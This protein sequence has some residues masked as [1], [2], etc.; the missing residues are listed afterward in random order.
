MKR[1]TLIFTGLISAI[2]FTSALISCGD[3]DDD[4][5]PIPVDTTAYVEIEYDVD[6]S[7]T[8]YDY[9][10]IEVTYTDVTGQIITTPLTR[11]W[12]YTKRV[13]LE[14]APK[15]LTMTVTAKPKS[16]DTAPVATQS[17]TFE[18]DCSMSVEGYDARGNKTSLQY[19]YE[20]PM[21]FTLQG[22]ALTTML[23]RTQELFN[24]VY[25]FK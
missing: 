23:S 20:A 17:V 11:D 19:E 6:L 15:T 2:I 5:A 16:N 1:I 14:S 8:W 21:I 12:E 4:K 10:D 13:Q 7:R 3:D 25:T 22:D 9:F 18:R 24:D